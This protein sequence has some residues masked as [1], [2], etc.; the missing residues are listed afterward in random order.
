MRRIEITN[1]RQRWLAALRSGIYRQGSRSLRQHTP[2]S[3]WSLCCLGVACEI[4]DQGAWML[5]PDIGDVRCLWFVE[6]HDGGCCCC[7]TLT[8][9]VAKLVGMSLQFSI[10]ALGPELQE[11]LRPFLPDFSQQASPAVLNDNHVPFSLIAD[12]LAEL[13]AADDAAYAARW[14]EIAASRRK[15]RA[16]RKP[17]AI[18]PQSPATVSA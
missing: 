18:R 12:V 10:A 7:W 2:D 3:G 14:Q 17:A 6:Y 4:S 8:P 16:S 5:R 9:R 11:R 13:F 15:N 1:F